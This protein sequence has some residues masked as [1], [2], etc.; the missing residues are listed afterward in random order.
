MVVMGVDS[1]MWGAYIFAFIIVL[2]LAIVP[3][4]IAKKKGYSYGG[5]Y[6]F[7]VFL[8]LIALI[9]AL[10]MPDK[11]ASKASGADELM[12]YKKL[13]DDGAITQAEYEAKKQEILSR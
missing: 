6:V 2:L 10:V 4:R 8:W 7:G 1:S 13:L 11:N 12:T 9:V 3:A 5:F